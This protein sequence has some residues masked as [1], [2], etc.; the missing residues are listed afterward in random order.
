MTIKDR[1]AKVEHKRGGGVVIVSPPDGEPVIQVAPD[2]FQFNG[3]HYPSLKS[4]DPGRY[5]IVDG[6]PVSFDDFW[7]SGKSWAELVE[8]R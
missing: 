1:L 4:L 8:A 6:E 5:H 2:N 7:E 3:L